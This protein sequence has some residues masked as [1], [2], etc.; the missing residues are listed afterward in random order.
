MR[1]HHFLLLVPVSIGLDLVHANPLLIF[2]I[3]GISIIPVSHYMVDATKVLTRTWGK[4]IAG[5]VNTTM[6]T[7]PDIVIGILAL[8]HGLGDFVKA[9]ITG[10]IMC[11]LL[12]GVGFGTM[13]AARRHPKGVTFDVQACHLLSGLMLLAT[14]GLIIPAIFSISTDTDRE[15]SLEISSVLLVTYIASVIFTLKEPG[16]M[17]DMP[18]IDLPVSKEMP[19]VVKAEAPRALGVLIASG[20]VLALM[21]EILTHAVEP[22][23]NLL[24]LTPIFAGIFLLAPIGSAVEIVSVLRFADAKQFD[25]ALAISLGCSAQ[26]ALLAAPLLVLIGEFMGR[27]MNLLFSEFQV[28][29]VI[30][31]VVAVNYMLNIGTVRGISGLKLIAIYIMLGIGFYYQPA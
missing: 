14:I 31:A 29:A 18:D 4:N 12:L 17:S 25:L 5:L 23:A 16:K 11:N 1:I 15:I 7:I 20:I 6:G 27:P 2:I 28:L 8:S 22:T 21:S 10:A 3:T 30:I 19:G 24:G 26:M 9:S 13:L